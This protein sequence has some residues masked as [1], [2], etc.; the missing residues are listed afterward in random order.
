MVKKLVCM[1]VSIL[2]V[3][4]ATTLVFAEGPEGNKRKG[5]YTYKGVYKACAKR[6]EVESKTPVLSPGDKTM[7]KSGEIFQRKM[8]LISIHICIA[9]LQILQPLQSVNNLNRKIHF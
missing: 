6:G 7:A 9:M 4:T 8:F 2:F 5:K 3:L 1:A